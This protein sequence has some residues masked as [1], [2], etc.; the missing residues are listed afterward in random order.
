M[1]QGAHL[2]I[3][4]LDCVTALEVSRRRL[5][6]RTA[7]TPRC[8]RAPARAPS[9]DLPGST[10]PGSTIKT[11][12]DMRVQLDL[13]ESMLVEVSHSTLI[14]HCLYVPCRTWHSFIL[15]GSGV[16]IVANRVTQCNVFF[17]F[18][19]GGYYLAVV[20]QVQGVCWFADQLESVAKKRSS[21]VCRGGVRSQD[22]PRPLTASLEHRHSQHTAVCV[23]QIDGLLGL[24]VRPRGCKPLC[25]FA[26]G[27]PDKFV[28]L[29]R[30]L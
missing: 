30:R 2:G 7:L 21:G 13:S 23:A 12:T 24:Q 19:W 8:S 3:S 20:V 4:L 18:F 1:I 29:D 9:P 16:R 25:C 15:P 5:P 17:P 28:H 27:H 6:C 11:P 10:I 14:D 26:S 22:R